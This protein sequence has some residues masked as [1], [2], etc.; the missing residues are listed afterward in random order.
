M[1][2]I[3]PHK[4]HSLVEF[5]RDN[6]PETSGF[7]LVITKGTAVSVASNLHP[8]GSLEAMKIVMAQLEDGAKVEWSEDDPKH[9]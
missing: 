2:A 1:N 5:I 4:L 8:A 9:G 7:I 6:I 3:N